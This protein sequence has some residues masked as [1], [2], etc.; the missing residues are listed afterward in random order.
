MT[1]YTKVTSLAAKQVCLGSVKLATRTLFAPTP[2]PLQIFCVNIVFNF[3]WNDCNTREKLKA[4]VTQNFKG[5][6][7]VYYG[8]YAH[9]ELKQNKMK[10]GQQSS[11][12]FSFLFFSL[13]LFFHSECSCG[14]LCV[15]TAPLTVNPVLAHVSDNKLLY[16]SKSSSSSL[17]STCASVLLLAG[18]SWAF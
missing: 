3:S 7:K 13:F 16:S 2:P 8:R 10:R 12:F 15:I 6:N 17:D 1:P 11:S 18:D 9:G 5:P 14:N 4:K